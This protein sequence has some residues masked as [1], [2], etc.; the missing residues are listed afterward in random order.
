MIS[1]TSPLRSRPREELRQLLENYQI[2]YDIIK[3]HDYQLDMSRGKPCAEQLALSSGLLT[4]IGEGQTNS[5]SGD[6]RNYGLVSGIPETCE[7]FAE[8]L[9]VKKE[10]IFV[11]GNS[12]LQ[13]MYSCITMALLLGVYGGD[14]PWKDCGKVKFLCPAPGYDRHF[15]IT[16]TFGFEML[17]I[18]MTDEGPHMDLIERLVAEDESIKGIWCVPMYSNPDGITYSDE[19]VRR[20][21]RLKPAAKDF[22]I[23]WDNAYGLHHL[24]EEHDRLLNI[25]EEC[26]LAGN[27]HMVYEFTSTSKISFAGAGVSCIAA[28]AENIKFLSKQFGI[29]TIGFDKI[30]QLRHVAFFKNA[31]GVQAHMEKHAAILRPK[32]ELVLAVLQRKLSDYAQWHKPRG[33]YF[34]SVNVENGCAKEV[35]RMCKEAGVVLTP[36]GASYPYGNDPFDRNIRLAPSYP[37]LEE[38]SA[39]IELF[40]LAVRI[41]TLRKLLAE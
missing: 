18:P 10:E 38:L 12:S 40:C 19:T 2:R 3:A 20:F 23:F 30:N 25:I 33:G 41:V 37:P 7:F 13:L 26:R 15:A 9:N 11:G 31:A 8:L 35:V 21:A 27:P 17:P 29:Q 6:T 28:S 24:Y 5:I 1:Q 34:I 16:E 36:A 4:C 32:F 14:K 22:R 39:A